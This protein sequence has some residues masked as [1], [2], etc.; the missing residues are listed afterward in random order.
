MIS[1]GGSTVDKAVEVVG[2]GICGDVSCT[3]CSE[4]GSSASGDKEDVDFG[5]D[6][7]K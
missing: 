2:R 5:R 1:G 6:P 4:V 3:S 7:S